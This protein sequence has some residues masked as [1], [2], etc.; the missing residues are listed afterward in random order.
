MRRIQPISKSIKFALNIYDNAY[1]ITSG[2]LKNL[3]R[4]SISIYQLMQMLPADCS[5][6]NSISKYR[7][8][9][10]FISSNINLQADGYPCSDVFGNSSLT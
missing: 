7:N 6:P 3:I 9:Y 5:L 1:N 8:Y 2:L 4:C 10:S